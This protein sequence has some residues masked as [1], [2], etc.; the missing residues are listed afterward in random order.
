MMFLHPKVQDEPYSPNFVVLMHQ[1]LN[2]KQP[3][4][5]AT[6]PAMFGHVTMIFESWLAQINKIILAL[7]KGKWSLWVWLVACTAPYPC[8]CSAIHPN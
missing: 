5:R 7:F 8:P 3:E 6:F 1:L 4:P 2:S